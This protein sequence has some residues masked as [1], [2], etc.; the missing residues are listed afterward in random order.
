M[1]KPGVYKVAWEGGVHVGYR[2]KSNYQSIAVEEQIALPRTQF[3]VKEI[4]LGDDD[5]RAYF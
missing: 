2:T 3:E 1:S 4:V 5:L